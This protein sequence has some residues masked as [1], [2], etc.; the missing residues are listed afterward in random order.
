MDLGLTD[1]VAM[2]A[3]GTKGIGLAIANGLLAEG[4]RVSVCSRSE[5]SCQAAEASFRGRGIA[6][7]ADV[8]SES[9]LDSWYCRTIETLGPP[10]I[11]VTSTGG[12]PAGP[13]TGLS[14]D[15]WQAGF[16]STL[17]NVVRLTRLASQEMRDRN[18]GRIIHVT[19]LVAKEPAALL[20][21]SSTLRSGLMALC[22]LQATELAPHG[23]TVNAILPGHTLTDRQTHL[24]EIRAA[25][26]A[27]T[28]EEALARQ[29]AEVPVGRL[30][31][32]AEIADAAVFL[33]SQRASYITGVNLLVD[34]GLVKGFG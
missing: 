28:V 2:V 13:W 27:I 3:A 34:G 23:I 33:A 9:D 18:W 14:D 26:D 24:A 31:D 19:S 5:A 25:R 1:K 30:A 17:M 16:D 4:A 7:V 20:P 32:P 6:T 21:I 15:Q 11:L 10:D 29:A 12:P 8:S 22:R